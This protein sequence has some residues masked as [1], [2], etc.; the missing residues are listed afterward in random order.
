MDYY[1]PITVRLL[2]AYR[3][4]DSQPIQGDNI[5]SSKREIES[6]LEILNDALEKLL[7]SI[8]RDAAWD[9]STDARIL[10]TML[11]QEGLVGDFFA[12]PK[13]SGEGN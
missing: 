7:D 3:D 12:K 10:Q 1:L 2:E 11:A 4:L 5:I 6:T 13:D 9:V 8:F